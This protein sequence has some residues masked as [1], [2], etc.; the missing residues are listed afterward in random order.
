MPTS[1]PGLRPRYRYRLVNVFAERPFAGKP[2]AV[3]TDARGLDSTSMQLIARE[4]NVPQTA[5]V[6]PA[7]IPDAQ[8]RVRIFTPVAELPRAEQPTIAAIFALDQEEKLERAHSQR[9]VVVQQAE[10][11]VSASYFARVLTV[12]Q[13]L[14]EFV[15]TYPEPDAVAAILGLTRD[16]LLPYPLEAFSAGVPFL[17]VPVR[18]AARLRTVHFRDSI[19]ERTVRHFEAPHLLAFC[20]SPERPSSLARARVFTPALGIR[21]DPA[22]EAAHG[23]LV[24]YA[25]RHSLVELPETAA[26]T[27]EQGAE[28]GRPSFIQVVVVHE[29]GIA[30]ELRIGGQ[31]QSVGEGTIVAP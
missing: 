21:E 17:L 27:I 24:V 31:C 3:I 13:R 15:G 20:L 30:R 12:K 6:F 23:A 26:V 7:E 8:A 22:T 9:R 25:L 29:G 16:D 14:P 18:D 28:L 1:E 2:T 4:L 5:F 11:P 10:G 19:W